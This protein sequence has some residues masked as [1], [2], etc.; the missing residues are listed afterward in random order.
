MKIYSS[1]PM[2]MNVNNKTSHS[3]MQKTTNPSFQANPITTTVV[4]NKKSLSVVTALLSAVGLTSIAN[5]LSTKETNKVVDVESNQSSD[6]IS[7]NNSL[8]SK[9]SSNT[10]SVQNNPINKKASLIL[11][12]EVRQNDYISMDDGKELA[13]NADFI[14]KNHRLPNDYGVR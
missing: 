14:S 11:G 10:T 3:Y 9:P 8:N 13:I 2:Y 6:T 12:R 7:Q 5:K 1:T 4:K